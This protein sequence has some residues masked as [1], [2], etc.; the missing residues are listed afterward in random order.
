LR[1]RSVYSSTF[2]APPVYA[3][4]VAAGLLSVLLFPAVALTLRARER[5]RREGGLEREGVQSFCDSYHRLLDCIE[6]KIETVVG[7]GG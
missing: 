1:V 4:L 3:A 5:D 2:S 6:S 7:D